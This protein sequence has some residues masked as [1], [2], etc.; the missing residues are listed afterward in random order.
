MNAELYV[1]QVP[2]FLPFDDLQNEQSMQPDQVDTTTI[3]VPVSYTLLEA[4]HHFDTNH[5]H[6][7]ALLDEII[8]S[9][10]YFFPQ[11]PLV[12]ER[13][14]LLAFVPDDNLEHVLNWKSII[15]QFHVAFLKVVG[16]R[17]ILANH[18]DS[19][20]S[21][22]S[23]EEMG[24]KMATE[25]IRSKDSS[26]GR[27][28]Q[29][30]SISMRTQNKCIA[31]F[32]D[33]GRFGPSFESLQFETAPQ[34]NRGE[35]PTNI[36]Q[37]APENL[38]INPIFE[39]S[40]NCNFESPLFKSL[41]LTINSRNLLNTALGNIILAELEEQIKQIG[42]KLPHPIDSTQVFEDYYSSVLRALISQEA[43]QEITELLEKDLIENTLQKIEPMLPF[44]CVPHSH[45][46]IESILAPIC[47][48]ENDL[49]A[50][51]AVKLYNILS[52]G[53]AWDIKQTEV[54][55]G[56]NKFVFKPTSEHVVVLCANG[57]GFMTIKDKEYQ[58]TTSGLYD[59]CYARVSPTGGLEIDQSFDI[60]RF[61]VYPN[62]A[63]KEIIHELPA[64]NT[65]GPIQFDDLAPKLEWL[66]NSGVTAVHVAGAI[67][68]VNLYDLT[69]TTDHVVLSKQCGG[70][71]A[72]KV[73]TN[74]AKELGI[75]VLIDFVPLVALRNSSK[76][77]SMF[78]TLTLD[79]KGRLVTSD[80][81]E[82]DLMGLNF[83]SA[84][85]WQ[86]LAT[87]IT[88]LCETCDISGFF[89]G[90]YKL[91]D[92]V[93]PRNLEELT[94]IDPD[95]TPHYNFLNIIEGTVVKNDETNICGLAKRQVWSSPFLSNLM[96][97]IWEKIPNAFVWM[98]CEEEQE[99]IIIKSGLIPMNEGFKT[100]MQ[101]A[102]EWSIHNDSV[103]SCDGNTELMKYYNARNQ[104]NPTGSFGI[105][106]FGA[107]HQ[108]PY[109]LPYEGLSLAVDNLFYLSEV[110]LING[111]L[112]EAISDPTAYVTV[113]GQGQEEVIKWLPPAAKF[114][115]FLKNRAA[116]RTRADWALGG[117][118]HVL[119][120]SYD[121]KAM[122]AILSVARVCPKTHKCALI[123]TSFYMFN[124][125]YEVSVSDLP[126]F[127]DKPSDSVV[128]V[129]PI[130]G[131]SGQPSFY[132]LS[133]VTT[134]GSSL[135]LDLGRFETAIYEI[136]LITP[137]VPPNV[138]RSLVENIYTRLERGIHYNSY[139]VLSN[140]NIFN[141]ILQSLE[142]NEIEGQKIE[143][144]IRTLPSTEEVPIIFREALYFATRSIKE[145]KKLV[146]LW[147]EKRCEIREQKAIEVMDKVV[148]S[149]TDFI[150]KFGLEVK[151]SN[152]LGP[153]M[154]VAPE[155]GP[156][157]KVGGL[158]TMV[159][160][161]AK[162]LVNLG[163]DIHVVSPY[164]NVS[165]KGETDYL[166]KYGVEY[167]MNIDVY[168][169]DKYE[170]G[171]HYGVVDGVKCWFVH[172]YTFFAAPYQTGSTYFKLQLLVV[173]AK[174]AL[175]L[176]CQARLFPSLII[177]NDWMTGL[178][179]AYGRK[180]FGSVFQGSK[181][182]H[183]FHN[184]G[185]GY[186]GK[187][188]PNDGNTGAYRN[189]HQ[190]PDELLVDSFDHSFDPSLCALLCTDQWA[191]VSKKYRDE[192][193]E[194]SPYNYF[195]RRFPEPF[196]YSN[197]IR[198]Q[199][200]LDALEKLHMSHDEA[201][202]AVQQ[203]YFGEVDDN[204]CL[205]VFVG[206][207]VEQKGVYLII[208]SFEE[209]NRQYHGQLQFI[210]GG[211]AA[212][213]DR[214]YGL[215]CT[216]RMWDLKN[217]YP[218]QFWADPS[219]FFGDGLLACHAADYTLLPSLFEPSGIVQQEAFCSGCPVIAFR[220]GGLA[221][222]VFEFDQEKQTG[223]G[224]VFWSHRHQ[225]FQMA[226]QRAYD[227]FLNKP[228]YWK[229]RKNAF[230]STLSTE[231]V[232]IAW[233]REFARLFM[234]VFERKKPESE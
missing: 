137:E 156:F 86:L 206:R 149:K 92:Y 76:K 83:R 132:A 164:Y 26:G 220:T 93:L 222:T 98:Q 178:V 87:E 4:L 40:L 121:Q 186:A 64:F 12:F 53:H 43:E 153:I 29:L 55:T 168:A 198:V 33:K 97:R 128:E 107:L 158:S 82:T 123:C 80:I 150:H 143:K 116:T 22:L 71:N 18:S 105:L 183:I 69:A 39:F 173:M 67:E 195:L 48:H 169:P 117:D 111:C 81:P 221:D 73:F 224:F 131:A 89:M 56:D 225:D 27:P 187:I 84:K 74:R 119:P 212:P 139:N 125:I 28:H 207:I 184:L 60:G 17:A 99:P 15:L 42:L 13:Q 180:H 102:I 122:H 50:K 91:W 130:L 23:T 182:I 218:K 175:E 229:L 219:Q 127:K 94:R 3:S 171:V 214:S 197:G 45:D 30:G 141:I 159:W 213:D 16:W 58:P 19:F 196:A 70:L 135:F 199:E 163:L 185:V 49:M 61:I 188:W 154:F 37:I 223:N 32:N 52:N 201:K 68:R 51:R 38:E 144:L 34:I 233:S 231:T 10:S 161:L 57:K 47:Y 59:Y 24:V 232:A 8:K 200:R 20:G 25:H 193:L 1:N 202:R 65:K 138:R 191:T 181:F 112:E 151:K 155:L 120:V 167:N 210:V 90:D 114:T 228:L 160:E 179:P 41:I 136:E 189:V 6:I 170:I 85:L 109:N 157:S 11:M 234:K 95:N 216:H 88:Q 66:A 7:D 152:N 113:K 75:R 129:R 192:L 106:P 217:R 31:S 103:D 96:R 215:P 142:E 21:K 145:N 194:G 36:S 110:P 14:G 177:S 209:L 115:Q 208:D 46:F 174:S 126:I 5:K 118:I 101:G 78:S 204:K 72:F 124:L 133:E 100:V 227:L 146:R 104:R 140:N 230:D 77:Y 162:E 108:R 205:F 148:E 165:P 79:E 9:P 203:K 63:K 226:V 147:D 172:H 44:D 211:Q 190:L 176:C 62:G 2:L 54:T 166:K 134:N 35:S